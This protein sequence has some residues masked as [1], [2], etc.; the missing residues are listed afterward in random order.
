VKRTKVL[1]VDHGDVRIGLAISCVDRR[2]AFPLEVRQ[3]AH[4][5]D[6]YFRALV[7]REQV[8]LLVV[9][10]PV[11]TSGEEGHRAS[12]AR[13][14]GK[15]LGELTGLP[16][17]Y[18]DERFTTAFAESALWEAGLSHKK[19]KQRRDKVAAQMLLQAFLDA[20]CPEGARP[21]PLG[22]R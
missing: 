10:L 13:E 2:F 8:G 16:V 11:H 9:G 20:G 7:E 1:A 19:R 6:A 15:W 22:D 17:A 3:R 21:G 4:D 5:D 14:F 18:Y 12:L